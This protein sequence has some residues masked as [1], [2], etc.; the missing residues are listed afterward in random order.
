MSEGDSRRKIGAQVTAKACHVVHL[1]ECARRHGALRTTKVV[2]GTVV[3]VNNTRKAPNNRVSTFITADFDIGGGSV[4]RSTLNIRSV[5]LFKPDQ[6]TVPSSP[7][8][9][10]P[11]V[12]K[13]TQIWPF[14]SKRKEKR[15]CR[16][17]LLMKNWNFQHNR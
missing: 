1:S 11:A 8:A 13:Q 6:S 15:S 2:V 17:L 9:P 14:Q 3:E 5:K 4:K 10:I 7:A 12:D 16:R